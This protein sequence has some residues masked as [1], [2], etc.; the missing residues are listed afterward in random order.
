MRFFGRIAS[1][2]TFLLVGLLCSL[3]FAAASA[4]TPA[5]SVT[6]TSFL[7]LIVSVLGVAAAVLKSLSP[8]TGVFHSKYGHLLLMFLGLCAGSIAAALTQSGF[9]LPAIIV[10]ISGAVSALA[11]SLVPVGKTDANKTSGGGASVASLLVFF[12][13]ASLLIPSCAC[14]KPEMKDSPQCRAL[15]VVVTCGEP[16]GV[17]GLEALVAAVLPAIVG[18]QINWT[19]LVPV[20]AQYGTNAVMCALAYLGRL[21]SG[22]SLPMPATDGMSALLASVQAHRDNV[23]ANVDVIFKLRH[24]TVVVPR[25]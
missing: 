5:S 13:I 1:I 18:S 6:L 2:L 12:T 21:A 15:D 9:N 8:T 4:P 20:E 24:V 17:S 14:S 3:A 19:G 7:P 25:S 23:K 11:G 16:A 22:A 10:A